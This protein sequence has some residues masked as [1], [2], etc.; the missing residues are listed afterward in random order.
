MFLGF[1]IF[2]FNSYPNLN[3]EQVLAALFFHSNS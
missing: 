1:R 2:L 3:K